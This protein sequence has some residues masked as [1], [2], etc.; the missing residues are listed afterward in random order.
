TQR[1]TASVGPADRRKIDEYLTSIREVEVR[2]QRA[3][4]QGPAQNPP[5]AR[6]A[7]IPADYAEHAHLM[8]E[9]LALAYQADLTRVSTMMIGRESSIRSYDCIGIPEPHHQLS[10]H[11]NQAEKLA[12]LTRIQTFHLGLFA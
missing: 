11:G 6:P 12:K 5:L 7:A 3:Q 9:M 8:F 4:Q 10:H 1:L 2:I